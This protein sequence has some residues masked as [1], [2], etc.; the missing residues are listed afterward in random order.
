MMDSFPDSIKRSMRSTG[1]AATCVPVRMGGSGDWEAVLFVHVAGPECKEDRRLLKSAHEPTPVELAAT[2]MAH[3]TAAIV[4][5]ELSIATVP[6]DPLKYE[7]LLVP[8]RE[9]THYQAI[10]LL[11]GQQR[12][13]W[14]FADNDYRVIQAQEQEI[15]SSQHELFEA[16]ARD[17]FAH[18]SLLRI[19]S[20]YDSD[21]A[22][23]EVV[24]HYSPRQNAGAGV[25]H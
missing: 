24:S 14:F 15:E 13:C 23:S 20:R 9:E 12:I 8:G 10:K 19:S 17:A 16:M 4:S 22:L 11:A 25:T 3:E 7:I 5:I 18:D 6:D 21:K 1:S 2:L